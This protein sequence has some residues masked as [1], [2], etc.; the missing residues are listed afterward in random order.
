MEGPC[1]SFV[2]FKIYLV[3][4]RLK[5][6]YFTVV[7]PVVHRGFMWTR[8]GW[9]PY[10]QSEILLRPHRLWDEYKLMVGRS[11]EVN[12]RGQIGDK[13]LI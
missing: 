5:F 9:T 1:L 8:D 12:M 4:I 6:T 7:K 13:F 3:R 2:N 11:I 10:G